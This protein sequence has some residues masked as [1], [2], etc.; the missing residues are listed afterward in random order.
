MLVFFLT[1][2]PHYIEDL[3]NEKYREYC[4][5]LQNVF[6]SI[7]FGVIID[8]FYLS[9]LHTKSILEI[10]CYCWGEYSINFK[11]TSFM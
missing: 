10:F 2:K 3:D 5:A 11:N 4:I 8:I 9:K 6:L 7:L 1:S